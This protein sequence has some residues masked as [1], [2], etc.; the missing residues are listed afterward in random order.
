MADRGPGSEPEVRLPRARIYTDGGCRPNPGPGGWGA[1]ILREGEAPVELSGS[2]D[3]T[4]NNRMELQAAIEA[5]A[6]LDGPHEVVLHTDSTYL[7]RG[8]TE[9]LARWRASGW[10]TAGKTPV[11]NRD[12]WERLDRELARHRVRWAWVKGHAGDR[13]NE[14]ADALASA[15]IPG[16]RLPVDDPGAVHAWLAVAASTKRRLGAWSAILVWRDH[17][18]IVTGRVP[19]HS[20]N[21]L[22]L[23]GAVR[24]LEAL[25]RPSRV[26]LYTVSDYLAQGATSWIAGWKRRSWTTR[27]GRPVSNR[28]LWEAL[29][30][31]MQPHEVHWHAV[32]SDER[33]EPLGA[34]RRAARDALTRQD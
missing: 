21:R 27:D 25:R 8:I 24:A 32:G 29:D 23:L 4:T 1:V 26:H 22:H 31:A 18:R 3:E 34:A 33:P 13:W 14:R 6:S 10:R 11:Q 28:D 12:L 7:K 2:A 19:E 16:V 9:W 17:E 20:A 15:A 30:R 5:L